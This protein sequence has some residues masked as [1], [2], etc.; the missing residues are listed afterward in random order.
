MHTFQPY[1]IDM[2]DINPF[3]KLGK[4]WA[5]V[6]AGDKEKFK[7]HDRF[8]G[9]NRCPLGQKCRIYFYQGIKIY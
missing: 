6:T 9:W 5:L 8:M 1:P 7:H 4:E 2:L 3:T